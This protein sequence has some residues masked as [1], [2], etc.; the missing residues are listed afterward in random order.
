MRMSLW[1]R[2]VG[3]AQPIRTGWDEY[4]ADLLFLQFQ[5]IL[6]RGEVILLCLVFLESP[7]VILQG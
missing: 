4:L 3:L 5:K 7:Q 1:L 6:Q 2:H